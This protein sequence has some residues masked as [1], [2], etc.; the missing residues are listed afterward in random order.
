QRPVLDAEQVEN[1]VL[2]KS[3]S[4]P[5][6]D[7]CL[8]AHVSPDSLG[9][10]RATA[11]MGCH[12]PDRP[13]SCSRMSADRN[14]DIPARMTDRF[15]SAAAAGAATSFADVAAAGRTHLRPASHAQWCVGRST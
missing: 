1:E 15:T 12:A 2:I 7:H 13:T 8:R 3:T 11:R 4:E 9:N 6:W 5:L 14:P 10:L